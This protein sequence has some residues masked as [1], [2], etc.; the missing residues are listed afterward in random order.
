M[1]QYSTFKNRLL[2]N[3]N[4]LYEVVMLADQYGNPIAGGSASGV[5]AD[6]FGR[7]RSSDPFTLF[8]SFNRYQES[9]KFTTFAP[10][11]GGTSYDEALSTVNLQVNGS[12]NAEV[13]RESTRVFAYQPGKSLL[14]MNSFKFNEQSTGLRQRVGYFGLQNGIYVELADDGLHFVLRDGSGVSAGQEGNNTRIAQADWN[15][16]NMDGSGPSGLTIDPT[17]VQ[18]FWIDIEWLGVGS[19]RCGFVI[20]GQFIHC[21]SFHH[22]NIINQVYMTTAILPIRYEIKNTLEGSAASLSQIC[23]TVISEG[24]YEMRGRPFY[25][26]NDVASGSVPKTI[27]NT[28]FTPLLSLRLKSTP[29]RL[30]AVAVLKSAG[31][32]ALADTYDIRI[33]KGGDLTGASWVSAASNSSIEYDESATA[34]TGGEFVRG[35]LKDMS[36]QSSGSV[37]LGGD[38]FDLQFERDGLNSIPYTYTIVVLANGNSKTGRAYL[39]WEEIT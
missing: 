3:G 9:N 13:I 21:H 26:A 23:S 2:G 12:L 1:A 27:S 5:G 20:N 24:G 17:A 30:D 16:D 34:I 11:G 7:A 19:V 22:S 32:V 4:T 15:V 14:I 38:I 28:V 18:L 25:V 31:I 6:A 35:V 39:S 29:N 8:D 37:D 33:V 10:A 36:N